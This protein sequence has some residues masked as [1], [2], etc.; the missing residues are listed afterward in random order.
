M[1]RQALNQHGFYYANYVSNADI[2][3][4]VTG[5]PTGEKARSF[6]TPV[7]AWGNISTATGR[8]TTDGFGWNVDYDINIVPSKDLPITEGARLW[9]HSVPPAKHDY[10]VVRVSQSLNEIVI[11]AKRLP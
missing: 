7:F 4:T 5:L 3:S 1:F 8:V 11:A 2:T 10:E 6:E 9:V